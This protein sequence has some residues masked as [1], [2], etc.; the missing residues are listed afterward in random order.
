MVEKL[1]NIIE[2]VA[3]REYEKD[4]WRGIL[5]SVA[6]LFEADGAALGEIKEQYLYYT[7][8]SSGFRRLIPDYT[9]EKYKVPLTRSAA[10]WAFK[11]GFIIVNDY[12]NF[13]DAVECWKKVGLKKVLVSLIT[14][15]KE[16]A[17]VL[18]VARVNSDK[19]FTEKDGRILR[20]LAFIFYFIVKEEQEKRKIMEKAIRD[21]LTNL[22]N[23]LYLEEEGVREI[24]RA[25]RYNYPISLIIFDLDNFKR[26]NDEY[27]HL[28]GD[29]V[30][31]KFAQIVSSNIRKTDIPARF[32]GE[33]FVVLL[34]N[35]DSQSAWKI[36]ERIRETFE[37]ELF[38]FGK[39]TFK[40]TVSAGVAT[41]KPEDDCSLECLLAMADS[42]LYEAKRDGKNRVKVY[43][44]SKVS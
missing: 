32:G 41:C 22:Y 23:R 30:L 5:D 19:P 17:G 20:D 8:I 7:K 4:N 34:P 12:Q 35:T 24:E 43:V 18:A 3:S 31:I 26:V 2:R 14:K 36:A 1:L 16:I 38:E 28:A 42:A 6:E 25:K 13:P 27:G 11:K 39:N 10:A 21:H 37:R 44:P 15:D 33:E 9:P 40:I 29:E